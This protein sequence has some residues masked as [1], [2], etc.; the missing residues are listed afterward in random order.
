MDLRQWPV[1]DGGT[2]G[3]ARCGLEITGSRCWEDNGSA[4]APC[5]VLLRGQCQ[6]R[7]LTPAENPPRIPLCTHG[8]GSLSL[9]SLYKMHAQ[10][11]SWQESEAGN[12]QGA[13]CIAPKHRKLV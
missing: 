4:R 8:H 6:A 7:H 1:M 9:L 3:A 12:G 5:L 2:P 13:S 11:S 10:G